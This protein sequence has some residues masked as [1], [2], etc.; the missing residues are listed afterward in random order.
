MSQYSAIVAMRKYKSQGVSFVLTGIFGG[1]GLLYASIIGGVII[2][3]LE[4]VIGYM[5][6][7]HIAE[8]TN[9]RLMFQSYGYNFPFL[10]EINN[11][12]YGLLGLRVIALI[13]SYVSVSENN[14]N[15]DE[16]ILALENKEQSDSGNELQQQLEDADRHIA[17]NR[18]KSLWP[19][20]LSSGAFMALILGTAW[21]LYTEQANRKFVFD[22]TL[23]KGEYT[24]D[25]EYAV[26]DTA[27]VFD[28]PDPNNEISNLY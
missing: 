14:R 25:V 3:C 9:S 24:S 15:I 20:F 16:Q 7:Q 6:G 26:E 4:F 18:D 13:I 17:Q 23:K 11:F 8:V 27:N 12:L 5:L 19:L 28:T 2:F 22:E 21:Y 10:Y 1:L